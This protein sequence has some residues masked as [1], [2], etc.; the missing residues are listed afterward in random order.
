MIRRVNMVNIRMVNGYRVEATFV[1]ITF[2]IFLYLQC[3][4]AGN[5]TKP[6]QQCES[7]GTSSSSGYASVSGSRYD[8][9]RGAARGP[10]VSYLED[11]QCAQVHYRQ[12]PPHPTTTLVEPKPLRPRDLALPRSPLI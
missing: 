9:V 8:N 1:Q 5:G 2:E 3:A 7:S 4:T 6:F 10:F 12:P 11:S